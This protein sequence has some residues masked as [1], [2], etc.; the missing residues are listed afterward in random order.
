[1][2]VAHCLK[3]NNNHAVLLGSGRKS[4]A[5]EVAGPRTERVIIILL[6]GHVVRL[7]KNTYIRTCRPGLRPTKVEMLP[8]AVDISQWTDA[9]LAGVLRQTPCAQLLLE[10]K[11]QGTT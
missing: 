2:G 6:R 8:S 7:Q 1:M 4:L 11:A 10:A 5:M 9:Q 3:N